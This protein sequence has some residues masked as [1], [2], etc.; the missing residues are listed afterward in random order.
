MSKFQSA[1]K[2]VLDAM[3][4]GIGLARAAELAGVT[5]AAVY[6]WIKRGEAD[7]AAGKR[8][9]HA[10]FARA[11][12]QERA[13]TA[14]LMERS[15]LRGAV[16]D[17][18]AGAWYLERVLPDEYGRRDKLTVEVRQQMASEMLDYLEQRLDVDTYQRVVA[19]LAPDSSGESEAAPG[20]H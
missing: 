19:A 12:R 1:R 8:T 6:Q 9:K 20:L 10:E 15:V 5:R 13:R 18:R 17:W 2:D 14:G 11:I 4:R 3:H 16:D 7:E